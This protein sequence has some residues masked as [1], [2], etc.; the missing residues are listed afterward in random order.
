[1]RWRLTALPH[2]HQ[3][4]AAPQNGGTQDRVNLRELLKST[5][6]NH[7]RWSSETSMRTTTAQL[8]PS[9]KSWSDCSKTRLTFSYRSRADAPRLILPDRWGYR[10]T[11]VDEPDHRY[12]VPGIAAFVENGIIYAPTDPH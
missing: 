12:P 9:S 2:R 8:R 3:F 1:M 5:S 6:K 10:K 11:T 4:S 7:L